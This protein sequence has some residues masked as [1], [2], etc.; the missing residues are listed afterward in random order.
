[1]KCSVADRNKCN[2][3]AIQFMVNQNLI[4]FGYCITH[5]ANINMKLWNTYDHFSKWFD[6]EYDA[7]A[8]VAMVEILNG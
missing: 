1:M 7:D 4:K 2:R 8:Y 5:S 3:D 6:N